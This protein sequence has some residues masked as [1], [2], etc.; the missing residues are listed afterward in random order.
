MR[1]ITAIVAVSLTAGN[2]ASHWIFGTSFDTAIERSFF[3]AVAIAAHTAALMG[4]T[5]SDS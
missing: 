4:I 5:N 1:A 2:F 3:Q